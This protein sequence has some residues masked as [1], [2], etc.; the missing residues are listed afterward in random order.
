[1]GWANPTRT[2]IG[3]P[4]MRPSPKEASAPTEASGSSPSAGQLRSNA[5]RSLVQEPPPASAN[6]E[7]EMRSRK[8]GQSLYPRP[9][10][11]RG[12]RYSRLAVQARVAERSPELNPRTGS[13]P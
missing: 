10:N 6:N 7:A 9:T 4:N 5:R 1:M 3:G 2:G 11:A 8:I 13:S 12:A